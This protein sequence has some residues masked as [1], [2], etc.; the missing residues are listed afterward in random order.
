M[1]FKVVPAHEHAS[2]HNPSHIVKGAGKV[3]IHGINMLGDAI[4]A[5][6]SLQVRDM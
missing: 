1:S 5:F 3:N 2:V 4:I 6:P